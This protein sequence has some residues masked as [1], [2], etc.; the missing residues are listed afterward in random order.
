MICKLPQEVQQTIWQKYYTKYVLPSI[1]IQKIHFNNRY[2]KQ[3]STLKEIVRQF[4]KPAEMTDDSLILAILAC[5]LTPYICGQLIR[6]ILQNLLISHYIFEIY[7]TTNE[8]YIES[9]NTLLIYLDEWTRIL[10][11]LSDDAIKFL[12]LLSL[13]GNARPGDNM[14]NGDSSSKYPNHTSIVSISRYSAVWLELF[15]RLPV[16]TITHPYRHATMIDG[17]FYIRR[18]FFEVATRT[19]YWVIQLI[20]SMMGSNLKIIQYI[21]SVNLYIF[22]FFRL[23]TIIKQAARKKLQALLPNLPDLD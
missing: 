4:T 6:V 9:E 16:I 1:S 10:P 23:D 15:L 14:E 21:I 8:I 11:D 22:R 12:E 5:E 17:R 18:I 2:V 19:P 20:D 7:M 13:I 3:R